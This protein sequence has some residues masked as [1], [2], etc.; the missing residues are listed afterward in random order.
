MLI[1]VDYHEKILSY[2]QRYEVLEIQ[3]LH[4]ITLFIEKKEKMKTNT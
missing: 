1:T 2:N 3:I 4:F